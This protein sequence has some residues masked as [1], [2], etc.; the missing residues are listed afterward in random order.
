MMPLAELRLDQVVGSAIRLANQPG[1][2]PFAAVFVDA[3]DHHD[4][5]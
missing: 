5:D 2:Y 1:A 3:D 4:D